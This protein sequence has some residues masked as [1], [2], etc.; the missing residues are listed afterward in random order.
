MAVDCSQETGRDEV[1]IKVY[2]PESEEN[3]APEVRIYPPESWTDIVAAIS[4]RADDCHT[5]TAWAR[6][7]EDGTLT[8]DS[9]V[10]QDV[11]ND[12]TGEVVI[13]LSKSER[14]ELCG[15]QL[16]IVHSVDTWHTIRV[17]AT[18]SGSPFGRKL[19]GHDQIR[20]LVIPGGLI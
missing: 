20:I 14:L 13:E 18:D 16:A 17:T 11:Y 19:S 15:S 4:D 2:K 3:T 1:T 7:L 12:G 8:G 9:L 6:D 10:W 5:L